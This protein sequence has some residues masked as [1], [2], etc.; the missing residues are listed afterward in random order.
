[1][2]HNKQFIV[3]TKEF[4]PN[5]TWKSLLLP[6]GYYLNYQANLAIATSEDQSIVLL[7][8]AWQVD[9]DAEEPVAFI[10]H[11]SAQEKGIQETIIREENSWNG[12]YILLVG[13][14]IY[15]DAVGTLGVFYSE[16]SFSS[17]LRL[18]CDYE[19]KPIAFPDNTRGVYPDFVPGPL[20]HI[21]GIKRLLPSQIYNYTTHALAHRCFWTS[22]S[23]Q[24]P[25]QQIHQVL[26]ELFR[27]S[28]HNMSTYYRHQPVWLALTGGKDSRTALALLEKNRIPYSLYTFSFSE[29][30]AK[31]NESAQLLAERVQKPH[32]TIALDETKY[33]E[34]RQ[35]EYTA[36][37]MLMNVDA[38]QMFYTHDM[39]HQL[40]E[41]AGEEFVMLRN[42]VWETIMDYYKY[43]Y[44]SPSHLIRKLRA[45]GKYSASIDLWLKWVKEDPYNQD[46]SMWDRVFWELREGCWLA[47]IEQSLDL[48][49]HMTCAQICNCRKILSYLHMYPL[50]MR[51]KKLHNIEFIHYI[52]PA[53]ND[54]PYGEANKRTIKDIIL[55]QIKGTVVED[56]LLH[57]QRFKRGMGRSASDKS[58]GTVHNVLR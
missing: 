20:T 17:S 9:K 51:E 28:L 36:H 13:D 15:P 3:S 11:H 55:K 23:R 5:K 50:A 2:V 38:D 34:M 1:M 27:T 4:L 58:D 19:H 47:S 48:V 8:D 7:G 39:Y 54:V 30:S 6:N 37:T 43:Y 32:L 26:E 42:N 57:M 31:D 49:D 25:P 45:N 35:E 46:I 53:C 21:D 12:R 40:A 22:V 16:N 52:Y 14:E 44:S 33:D 29:S 56:C 18:L 41:H 24:I 10:R